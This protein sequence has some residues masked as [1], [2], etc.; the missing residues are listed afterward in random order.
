MNFLPQYHLVCA[1]LF[2]AIF[3]T[4]NDTLI[5]FVNTA[6]TLIEIFTSVIMTL[7]LMIFLHIIQLPLVKFG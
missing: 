3:G 2:E 4:G 5:K 1:N 7:I 6:L